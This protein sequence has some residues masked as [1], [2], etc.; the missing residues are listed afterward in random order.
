MNWWNCWLFHDW[1]SWSDVK[2]GRQRM[3][4]IV[5]ASEWSEWL[6]QERFCVAC[7]KQ[8]TRDA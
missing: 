8:Q 2:V 5:T 4:I 1:G 7:N 6:Y 3:I